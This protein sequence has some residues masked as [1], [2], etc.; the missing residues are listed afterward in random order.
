MLE[1]RLLG[2]LMNFCE[3]SKRFI[4]FKRKFTVNAIAESISVGLCSVKSATRF[5]N[6]LVDLGYV[7]KVD[8]FV[9]LRVKDLVGFYEEYFVEDDVLHKV[10]YNGKYELVKR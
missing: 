8:G 7:D 9:I 5:I 2:A 10:I 1:L 3:G 6:R 4:F